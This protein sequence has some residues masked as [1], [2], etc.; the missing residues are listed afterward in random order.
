MELVPQHTGHYRFKVSRARHSDFGGA[1]TTIWNVIHL[2]RLTT[3]I[4]AHGLMTKE[5]YPQP[6]QASLDDTEGATGEKVSFD[7]CFGQDYLGTVTLRK[8][9]GTV[10]RVYDADG[11]GPDLSLIQCSRYWFFWVSAASVWK[12]NEKIL[13]PVKLNEL[14]AI[15]DYEGK[16]ECEFRNRREAMTIL[17]HRLHSPP[18]K[19]LRLLAHHLLEQQAAHFDQ[20]T[21]ASDVV[22]IQVKKSKDILFKPLEEMA[23][24]R[25]EAACPDDAEI[26]LSTWA[27][28]DET[29]EIAQARTVLRRFAVRWWAYY[30]TK[31]ALE[32]LAQ[33]HRDRFDYDAVHDGIRRVQACRYFKWVRG[34]RIL[35][36]KLPEEWHTDF[37]DGIRCWKLPGAVLP[38]GRMRNIPTETR[39]QELLTREKIFR[40]RFNWYLEKGLM[41][42]VIPRFTVPKA[43]DVRVVWDSRSNGHN[44]CLWAPSFILGDFGDLEEIVVKWI[45]MPVETYLLKGSPDQDYTQE[46]D[47]FIK[48]WQ[49]DIDVGQQF[50]NYA[51]HPD[52]RPYCG[53]RMIDTK[54]DGSPERHW[55]MRFSALHFGGKC[56]PFIAG[57][58]QQRILEW[59]KKPPA[60]DTSPFQYTKVILNLP[61][62]YTWDPSLPRVMRI[63]K[64]GELASA[65]VNY[66]DD[67]HPV[68]R[69]V[70]SHNAVRVARFLKSRMNSVGNQADDKKYRPPTCRPGAWKGEI[71]HTDQPLP[72]KSTTQ[73]KWTRFKDGVIWVL[74]NSR[75]QSSV[76][77][78]E[79]RRIA[80]LGINVTD[81]YRDARC[82]LKGFF[83]AI[84]AFRAG[85]D[86]NGWRLKKEMQQEWG[87]EVQ[88]QSGLSTF[89]LDA[90]MES[91]E[92]LE[93]EDAS[94]ATAAADYPLLTPITPELITHCEALLSLF[95]HDV[96]TAIFIRP[97][98]SSAYRYYIGDAS[99]EGLGGATQYPDGTIRGRRGVW[100]ADFAEGGSNLRE[101][102]NQVNHLISE[103]RAGL[104]DGCALWA[105]TDNGCWSA[106]WLNGLST[107]AHLFYLVLELK[108]ECRRHEVYLCVCHISGTRMIESGIDGWSRGDFETGISLGYD[109]RNFIPLAR[110]A[111]EVAGP[112][113]IPW[114]KAWMA[115]DYKSPLTPDGWFWVLGWT[116]PRGAY[117]GPTSS[118]CAYCAEAACSNQVEKVL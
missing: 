55:F 103:V 47:N 97:A 104:H 30:Q 81:V 37:R 105:F 89:Q 35:Y 48:S 80:G 95:E 15:W 49:L 6:L 14:F 84:E 17:R 34:S 19:I 115:E 43:T 40:L 68:V 85:R 45:S 87:A 111:I 29:P 61:T 58:G 27:L 24:V 64:D 86:R 60:D 50:N 63:R 94:T 90:S 20:T 83:N 32:W 21:K 11:L 13:R 36:W 7:A 98:S 22:P 51:S 116:S 109:L 102:Q 69:G 1:T 107:A 2:S 72:R 93:A 8:H 62:S 39:E 10:L 26:D 78:A 65:E 118:S 71:M 99:R 53:V 100:K 41:H 31:K 38:R 18:G 42:L 59:A 56:S 79:L 67:I 33:G 70:D 75:S 54:N 9:P 16:L 28:P 92:R 52:D 112:T 73:K 4:T 5:H 96:P 106:V 12:R 76:A 113:M 57:V 117:L 77:T 3:P 25:A 66:V 23:E 101:A 114:L 82:Y 74:E 91:A 44:A 110:T 46:A 108:I 88:D